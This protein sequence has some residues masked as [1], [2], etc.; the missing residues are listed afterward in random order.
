M[1]NSVLNFND[2]NR[3]NEGNQ[4]GF[5]F[6]SKH[7]SK[8]IAN[9]LLGFLKT[10]KFSTGGWMVSK[11]NETVLYQLS[12]SH[13]ANGDVV[14]KSMQNNPVDYLNITLWKINLAKNSAIASQLNMGPDVN[15]YTSISNEGEE[16]SG[17]PVAGFK[18]V[19]TQDR[20]EE[21][22][23]PDW[24]NKYGLISQFLDASNA[25]SYAKFMPLMPAGIKEH[26][27][28][29]L[30]TVAQGKAQG[31]DSYLNDAEYKGVANTLLAAIG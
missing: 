10:N 13:N 15:L 20:Q 5:N 12:P 17:T 6:E 7:M 8:E 28:Q 1:K 25:K 31:D 16:G 14:A 26:M 21:W 23:R 11:A 9:E 22:E 27:K 2:W 18:L 19:G 24:R 3:I 29:Q 4:F 30:T